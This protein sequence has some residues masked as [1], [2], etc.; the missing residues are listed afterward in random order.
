VQEVRWDKGR[1]VGAG[2]YNLFYGKGKE[3]HESGTGFCVHH[4][5]LSAV[6]R[7]EFV[8]DR[9]PYIVL[10]RRW[11]S[12]ISL[13]VHAPSEEKNYDSKGSFMRN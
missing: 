10:K 8:S 5:M 13:N 4:R 12:I 11:C 7:A 6:K 1:A 3:N 2:D 9:M